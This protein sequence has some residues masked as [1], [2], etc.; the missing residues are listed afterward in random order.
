[1]TLNGDPTTRMAFAWFTN[2]SVKTGKVQIVLKADASVEDFSKP[3]ITIDAV[4]ADVKDLNYVTSKN[5][6]G[7]H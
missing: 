5:R 6:S 3:D 7:R 4:S 2:S 1:M